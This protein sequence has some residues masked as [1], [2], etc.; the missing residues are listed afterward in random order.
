MAATW[1]S[2]MEAAA[3]LKVTHQT[4]RNWVAVGKLRGKKLPPFQFHVISV[5]DVERLLRERAD[6]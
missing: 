6:A 1:I 3:L 4:I 2:V 5:A